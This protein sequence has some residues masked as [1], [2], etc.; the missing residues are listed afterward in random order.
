MNLHKKKLSS[1][2]VP[3]CNSIKQQQESYFVQ[4]QIS[5]RKSFSIFVRLVSFS[6][7]GMFSSIK[8]R[9]TI[10]FI[11]IHPPNVKMNSF[12]TKIRRL[13]RYAMVNKGDRV[14]VKMYSSYILVTVQSVW[15]DKFYKEPMVTFYRH[16]DCLD[17]VSVP[18]T[19]LVN[20]P[21]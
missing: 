1:A 5:S 13:Q 2:I 21:L 7:S 20:S 6:F 14:W 3:K 19:A 17:I 10:T 18:E 16:G 8:A 4:T 15:L 12:F 11:L 9:Q